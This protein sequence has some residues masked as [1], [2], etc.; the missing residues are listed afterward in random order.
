MF[1]RTMK[2]LERYIGA[3]YSNFC[4]SD[5][6][7]KTQATLPYPDMPTIIPDTVVNRPKTDSDMTYLEKKNIDESTRQKLRKKDVYETDMQKI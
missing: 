1:T 5:I 6:M 2:E 7:T 4:Q 3:T